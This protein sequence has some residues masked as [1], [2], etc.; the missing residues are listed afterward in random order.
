VFC[1][2]VTLRQS[3]GK[4]KL[5][6]I[7]L[8]NS[9]SRKF[10]LSGAHESSINKR[11]WQKF[12]KRKLTSWFVTNAP[13]CPGSRP[14]GSFAPLQHPRCDHLPVTGVWR[15]AENHVATPHASHSPAVRG[16]HPQRATHRNALLLL[17]ISPCKKVSRHGEK[18]IRTRSPFHQDSLSAL[19]W[20][21]PVDTQ[22][23]ARAA[24]LP[25]GMNQTTQPGVPL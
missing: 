15:A 8:K 24:V 2:T 11:G 1:C 17:I 3:S 10:I 21:R 9:D 14:S 18:I 5:W 19:R 16:R 23:A 13:G 7:V 6:P 12:C 25:G 4:G 22:L 20:N